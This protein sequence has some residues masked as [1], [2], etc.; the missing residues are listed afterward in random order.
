MV[1]GKL[2]IH[3]QNNEVKP[4]S[5]TVYK[6]QLKPAMMVYISNPSI[7]VQVKGSQVEG[8]PRLHS[9][10]LSQKPKPKLNQ[11]KRP[12]KWIKDLN[13]KAKKPSNKH[14][15][16]DRLYKMDLPMTFLEDTRKK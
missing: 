13:I 7:P 3:T 10:T 6:S 4:L 12:S 5:H 9:E 1:L 15:D 16:V 14:V 8:Q 2:D 11:T